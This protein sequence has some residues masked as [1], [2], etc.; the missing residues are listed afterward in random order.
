MREVLLFLLVFFA[1]AENPTLN[2]CV[3]PMSGPNRPFALLPGVNIPEVQFN[4]VSLWYTRGSI[5]LK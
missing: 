1:I 3:S 5:V 2:S 4:A